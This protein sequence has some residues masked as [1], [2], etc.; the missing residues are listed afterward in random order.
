MIEYERVKRDEEKRSSKVDIDLLF[1]YLKTC[2]MRT[3]RG[4][5]R[6]PCALGEDAGLGKNHNPR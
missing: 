4:V 2:H 3:D 5:K 1:I 6:S